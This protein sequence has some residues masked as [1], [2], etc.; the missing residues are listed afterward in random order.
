MH[1]LARSELRGS[2]AETEA[3]LLSL[4]DDAGDGSYCGSCSGRDKCVRWTKSATRLDLASVVCEA[5]ELQG[6]QSLG[7]ASAELIF[8]AVLE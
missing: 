2:Q 3:A 4:G 8:P 7:L 1:L 5:M 6:L